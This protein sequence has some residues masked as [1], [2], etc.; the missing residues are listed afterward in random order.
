MVN[1]QVLEYDSLIV[2]SQ[3]KLHKTATITMALKNIAM[4]YP[5]AGYYGNPRSRHRDRHHFFED[6]H[7]FIVAMTKR[8][9]IDLAI[10]TGHPAMLATGPIGGYA[11]ETGLVLASTDAVAA[12]AVGA[13]LFGFDSQAVR[14]LWEAQQIGLGETDTEKMYFPAFSLSEATRIFT[15]K[16]YGVELDFQ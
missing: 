8:F 14:F 6:M 9:P 13:Q 7:S 10:T 5:A 16:A 1:P 4:S 3:L 11:V 12:D 15:K 2:L